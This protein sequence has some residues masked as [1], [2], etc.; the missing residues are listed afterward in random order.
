[1]RFYEEGSMILIRD[2]CSLIG[3]GQWRYEYGA[4]TFYDSTGKNEVG[5]FNVLDVP[6]DP[7]PGDVLVLDTSREWMF[8]SADPRMEC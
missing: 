8:I 6:L 3:E 4:L 1:M 2:N 7:I 5:F